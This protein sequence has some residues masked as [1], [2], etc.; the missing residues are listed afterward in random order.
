MEKLNLPD[1]L[2]EKVD[3]TDLEAYQNA[4]DK[5]EKLFGPTDLLINN[6]GVMLLENLQT[7]DPKNYK[8]ML[9]VNVLGVL[10]GTHIVLD[11]MIKRKQGTIINIS[12]IAGIKSF[13]NHVVYCATKAAVC[14]FSEAL[15]E[16]VCK[17]GV[18]VSVVCPVSFFFN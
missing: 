9:D 18:R 1:C 13:P 5:A 10:H 14:L 15:R 4:V 6:A 16:E 11:G 2:C 7:Q 12:S 3:I 17:S 8:K